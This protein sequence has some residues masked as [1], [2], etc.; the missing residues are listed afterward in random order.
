MV[1][2]FNCLEFTFMGKFVKTYN[3]EIDNS[4]MKYN[5]GVNK[6]NISL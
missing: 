6:I 1:Y 2:G 4:R 3:V 5:S